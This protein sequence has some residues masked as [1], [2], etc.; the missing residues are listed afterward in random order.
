MVAERVEGSGAVA[1]SQRARIKLS[2]LDQQFS[3]IEPYLEDIRALVACGDFT[4]GKAVRTFEER[5]AALC[6]VPHAIGVNSG[7]DA[8]FL[9]LRALGIGPGDEVITTPNTFIA[10]VGAIVQAGARPVVLGIDQSYPIDPR[11]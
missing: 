11:R 1:P 6:G 5:F 8:L 10:T 9:A 4:L 3:D 7:T 2:Y